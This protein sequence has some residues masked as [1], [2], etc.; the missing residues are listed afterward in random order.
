MNKNQDLSFLTQQ[1]GFLTKLKSYNNKELE[2]LSSQI[3][4]FLLSTVS[5]TGGHLA[6]NLGVVEL[7]VA[8]HKVFESPKDRIIWD[9]GHQSYVH[10]IL[11]QRAN[12]LHTI[13]QKDGLSGFTNIFESK[14]DHFGAGH[15]ST[16]LSALL[17]FT[18][19]DKL[20]NE[21]DRFNIAVIGDSSIVSGMA[22]EA[23]NMLSSIEKKCLVVLND[24]NMSISKPV[25][26]ISSYLAK[27]SASNEFLN[28]RNS[29][30]KILDK[31]PL[32][33]LSTPLKKLEYIART[34]GKGALFEELGFYYI[35]PIDG[36]KFDDLVPMLLKIK[37]MDIKKPILLH[38]KTKKGKG[39]TFAEEQ[40]EKY[41]GV[42]KF[43]LK[44]GVQENKN[45]DS[46]TAT[47]GNLLVKNAK[48]DK[49]I[50]AITP[51]M[52]T[53]SGLSEFF[54]QFKERAFDV[55]IAEQNAATFAGALAQGGF[56]VFL[57][58]YSTFAQRAY[59][60]IVHDIALQKIPVKIVLDRVGFVGADG[61]T[62]HGVLDL[63][64]FASLPNTII[65][66]P[67]CSK[68][69][70]DAIATCLNY[71]D[72]ISVLRLSK[73]QCISTSKP[74]YKGKVLELGKWADVNK[75]SKIAIVATGDI[76]KEAQKAC[77]MI[78]KEL[79]FAPTLVNAIF[80]KPVDGFL[81]KELSKTHNAIV[82]V[83]EGYLGGFSTLVNDFIL[84]NNCNVKI[85]N[86]AL[87]DSFFEQNT[88]QNQQELALIDCNAIFN[89][90]KDL[91]S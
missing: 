60:Q 47:F 20:A 23:M 29:S 39:Y 73:G 7:S 19:S 22:F 78:F 58:L 15:S 63:N 16:S 50:V 2:N 32:G 59:D 1:D 82:T 54:K 43:S 89:T 75:G 6:A 33:K 55:G 30:K 83:E 5:T 57:S 17:G 42:D 36:H 44:H 13:R 81:L 45:Q 28:L 72:G 85:K 74:D 61:A 46:Y 79:N 21:N 67:T 77:E 62:H 80:T 53:G 8:L 48:Q 51:A 66:S 88:R 65:L 11:T 49:K 70:E 4:D 25:G 24:N 31:T 69:M 35:G 27:I 56:K 91:V 9:I 87:R 86:L 84:Q 38:V 71:N 41:H 34:S 26:S 3:R 10:K 40:C 12:K 76:Y 68:S 37:Q 52:I 64:M 18:V 14:H 90:V